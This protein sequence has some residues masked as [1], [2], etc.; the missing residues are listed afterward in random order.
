M[1]KFGAGRGSGDVPEGVQR[2]EGEGEGEVRGRG[3]GSE[4]AVEARPWVVSPVLATMP[5]TEL[6][7]S[8]AGDWQGRDYYVDNHQENIPFTNSTKC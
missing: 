2:G 5:S 6:T 7:R 4:M 1:D 3:R 8:T